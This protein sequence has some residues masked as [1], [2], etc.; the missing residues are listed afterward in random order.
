MNDPSRKD[1]PEKPPWLRKRL[2]AGTD[3]ERV[4]RLVESQG[5]HTVCREAKCPN[6]WECF[7]A[8]TATFLILG[9]TCTRNCRFCGVESGFPEPPDPLEPG[10]LAQTA[11]EMK[12]E[13]V[14]VT[15]VTRDDLRDGGA[16][17]FART[18]GELKARDE[19]MRVE[20]LIPDFRGDRDALAAVVS[21]RPDVINHNIET[22]PG[23]YPKARPGADYNRSLALLSR[24]RALNPDILTKSGLMLGLGETAD[25]VRK[26][27][28]DL[29]AAGCR[30]V[31]L[32]Q[33]LQ[34]SKSHLPVAA[35]V[36]PEE[37][38]KW[39]S[40]ALAAGF[41]AAAAGPFVRSSYRAG[42]MFQ[43]AAAGT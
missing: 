7:S 34:P 18:I 16:F 6:Q 25:E 15:S 28:D 13:Y 40:Y 42:E 10:R 17:M 37:F 36:P 43:I 19:K 32:G 3:F 20:V 9:R 35:Y 24:V 2:G 5:L 31:T 12:L 38:E 41:S 14:V 26:A 8:G 22:V 39:R 21:A 33:Y 4:S 1:P 30:I 29:L 23:L 11:L 27:L